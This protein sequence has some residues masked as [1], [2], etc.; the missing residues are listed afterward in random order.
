MWMVRQPRSRA[1]CSP[2]ADPPLIA[3]ATSLSGSLRPLLWE[4]LAGKRRDTFG[5][6]PEL[7]GQLVP[8]CFSADGARLSAAAPPGPDT[9]AR[10]GRHFRETVLEPPSQPKGV[11][12]K[13]GASWPLEPAFLTRMRSWSIS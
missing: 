5:P 12:R 13:G 9:S 8:V 2:V 7:Q 11:F 6:F 10:C 3:A 4:P 1:L